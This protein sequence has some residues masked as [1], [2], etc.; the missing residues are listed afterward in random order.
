MLLAFAYRRLWPLD[1]AALAGA[2]TL[3]AGTWVFWSLLAF[4]QE[5]DN[6]NRPDDTAGMAFVGLVALL[7]L[8][9]YLVYLGRSWRQ[10]KTE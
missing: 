4:L 8:G 9:A 5:S 10:L 1:R 3:A 6:V 7:L 2:G